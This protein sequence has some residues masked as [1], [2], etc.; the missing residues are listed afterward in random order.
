MERDIIRAIKTQKE[1]ETVNKKNRRENARLV[2]NLIKRKNG[3]ETIRNYEYDLP[4][5][6]QRYSVEIE[7]GTYTFT[8]Q[9]I[10]DKTKVFTTSKAIHEYNQTYFE[11]TGSLLNNMALDL[12]KNNLSTPEEK[13]SAKKLIRSFYEQFQRKSIIP[14]PSITTRDELKRYRAQ[15][16]L[17]EDAYD[18]F[19]NKILEIAER[20]GVNNFLYKLCE[21][22]C[23]LRDI[24]ADSNVSCAYFLDS[25]PPD[26]HEQTFQFFP[27]KGVITRYENAAKK[28]KPEHETS[29]KNK[30]FRDVLKATKKCLPYSPTNLEAAY[31][32]K[33]IKQTLKIGLE[34]YNSSIMTLN[35][36]KGIKYALK[37]FG[38]LSN[39]YGSKNI[40]HRDKLLKNSKHQSLSKGM[41]RQWADKKVAY[42]ENLSDNGQYSIGINYCNIDG[43]TD[44]ERK[45]QM[46]DMI[47]N[48]VAVYDR[49]PYSDANDITVVGTDYKLMLTLLTFLKVTG[50]V[51]KTI[52][53]S[54]IQDTVEKKELEQAARLNFL[55]I[56]IIDIVPAKAPVP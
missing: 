24:N 13:K 52:D 9:H 23:N 26:H 40:K 42:T 15:C 19:F 33:A 18:D 2:A 5:Y 10:H 34:N 43:R 45:Q 12:L 51:P 8:R 35:T 47:S 38:F 29:Y 6:F 14:M 7:N 49:S 56:Q 21:A 37:I 16:K 32:H 11:T 4:S 25:G 30:T 54:E 48:M 41:A 22:T 1:Q 55:N 39:P 17:A 53:L 31:A 3:L 20:F 46:N 50:R 28:Y 44:E 27:R 36:D